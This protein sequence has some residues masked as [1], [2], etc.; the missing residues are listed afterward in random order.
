VVCG[1]STFYFSLLRRRNSAPI[2]L[3][4]RDF[5]GTPVLA[6]VAGLGCYL[7]EALVQPAFTGTISFW[8]SEVTPTPYKK[9]EPI[10]LP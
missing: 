8:C 2:H 1:Y 4:L 10:S 9:K 7:V 5:A 3:L 6:S